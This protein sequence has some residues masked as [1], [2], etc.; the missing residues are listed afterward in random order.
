MC[1]FPM[2]MKLFE[3]RNYNN[4]N[5]NNKLTNNSINLQHNSQEQKKIKKNE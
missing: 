2:P 4:N 1:L 5:N 3:P